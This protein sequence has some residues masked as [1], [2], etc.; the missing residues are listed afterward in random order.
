MLP[1]E[2]STEIELHVV[3]HNSAIPDGTDHLDQTYSTL[4][5][6]R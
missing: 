2:R 4:P 6:E 3:P 5:G 1:G